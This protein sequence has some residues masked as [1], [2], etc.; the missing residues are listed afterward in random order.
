MTSIG[1][2]ACERRTLQ[3]YGTQTSG[4]LRVEESEQ[5]LANLL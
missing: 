2:S 3:V 5:T 1:E 4:N